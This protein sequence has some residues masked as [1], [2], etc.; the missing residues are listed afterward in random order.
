MAEYDN[1]PALRR[2]LS[3]DDADARANAYGACFEAGVEP[4]AVLSDDPPEGDLEDA[5][6]I[7]TGEERE[8][9]EDREEQMITLLRE[10]RDAL[11]GGSP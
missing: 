8:T 1:L 9:R 3:S 11:T 6:V 4:S 7:P 5:G 2:A 10:I